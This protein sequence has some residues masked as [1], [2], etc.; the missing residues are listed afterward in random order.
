M[1]LY[2]AIAALLALAVLADFGN[3]RVC[4]F[5]GGRGKHRKDCHQNQDSS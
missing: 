5:C 3:E 1:T 2:L 4:A